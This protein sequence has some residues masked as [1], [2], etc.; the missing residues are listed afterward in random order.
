M[1]AQVGGSDAWERLVSLYQ[2]LIVTWLKRYSVSTN[3]ASD[4]TQDVLLAVS[5][6]LPKFEHNGQLG[7]FRSWLRRITINRC[8]RFW[9]AQNRAQQ[10]TGTDSV[11]DMI[12]QLEDPSSELTQR[13][14]LEHDAFVLKGLIQAIEFEFDSTTME[15]FRRSAIH[16]ESAADIA[17]QLDINVG[18]VYKS[19][20]QVMTRLREEADGLVGNSEDPFRE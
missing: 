20:F 14:D 18:K 17:K 6:E 15:A 4:I 12:E 13:W 5:T 2:P 16:G 7:A 8:R 1:Q 3:D 9:D 11:H 19:K 10:R